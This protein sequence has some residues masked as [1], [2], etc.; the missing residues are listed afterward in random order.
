MLNV[1]YISGSHKTGGVREPKNNGEAANK[2]NVDR[3]VEKYVED[4]VEKFKDEDDVFV[5]PSGAKMGVNKNFGLPFPS[6]LN[7]VATKEYAD[8]VG[9]DARNHA[10]RVVNSAREYVDQSTELLGRRFHDLP[11]AFLKDNGNFVAHTPISMASQPLNDLP[12]PQEVSDAV[13][14]KYVDDLIADNVGAGNTDGGD[15]PFSKE[16]GNYQTTHTINMGF[17]KLLNLST[18]LEPYEAAT[19]EYVDDKINEVKK[20]VDEK[21]P[22]ICVHARFRG[23]LNK[24]NISVCFCGDC[25]DSDSAFLVPHRVFIKKIKVKITPDWMDGMFLS[26]SLFS[27]IINRV[28]VITCCIQG[29]S[30]GKPL[31]K[32]SLY[33]EPPPSPIAVEEG[34]LINISPARVTQW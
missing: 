15:S 10:G 27:V 18:P 28:V 31:R 30:V 7:E 3:Y 13:T 26:T 8:R 17:K 24:R 11:L 23:T 20:T 12:E 1:V 22:I 21:D 29:E 32:A 9:I 16:N 33:F 5:S 19:K 14:K 6:K 25:N 34:S 2:R 4:Y